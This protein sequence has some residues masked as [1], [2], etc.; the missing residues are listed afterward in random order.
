V[1]APRRVLVTGATGFLGRHVCAALVRSGARVRGLIRSGE[2]PVPDVEVART[3]GLNDVPAL[4]AAMQGCDAVVHLAA[5]VHVMNDPEPDPLAAYRRVNVDGSRNVVE[6]AVSA[7]CRTLVH[8]SSVKAVG[9]ASDEAWTEAE[10]PR[11][12]DPYG[13]SKLESERVVREVAEGT[14]ME[15]AILRPPLVYG[16]G[17]RANMLRLFQLVHRGVP[18]PL[19]A[20]A[21]RRSLLYAG[22]VAAA[23]RAMVEHCPA[24]CRTFFVSD[25]P[26]LS[27]AELV[28]AIA[29]A[30][31]RPARLLAIP[32]ELIRAAGRVGDLVPRVP[33]TSAAVS[34][35][36]SSLEVDDAPLRQ[37]GYDPPFTLQDG[38]RETARWFH[39][40]VR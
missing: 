22:N 36:L 9:D 39:A 28:R 32:P 2:A 26:A 1:T 40:H 12:V 17:M 16:P 8:A 13:I 15:V 31:G 27:T 6:A 3:A 35:L 14:G 7:G 25:G 24:G 34:R 5:R 30:L 11:P 10:E 21:N 19:G 18:L 29:A 4:R 38:L 23:V 37:A 33:V 20:V